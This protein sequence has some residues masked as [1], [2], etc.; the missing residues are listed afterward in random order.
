MTRLTWLATSG[1][2]TRTKMGGG[3]GE[4]DEKGDSSDPDCQEY[5]NEQENCPG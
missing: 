5:E 2:C 3:D 1:N 4:E